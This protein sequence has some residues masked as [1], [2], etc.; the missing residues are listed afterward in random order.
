MKLSKKVGLIVGVVIIV[1]ALVGLYIVYS[2]QAR[3]RD[4]L[5]D[6][7]LRA[8]TLIPVLTANKQGQEDQLAS[9]TSSLDMSQA[10]FP[11]SVESIEYGEDLFEIAH[12]CNVDLIRLIPSMP[13]D[14]KVGAITYSV[15]QFVVMVR[16]NIENILEFI[17]TIRTG[18]YFQLPWSAEVKAININIAKLEASITLDIYGYKG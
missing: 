1:A 16:G 15:A 6:M 14:K 18:G 9:A 5:S 2:R 7:L 8:Q 17:Y 4:E 13:A 3:E 12:D 11:A 10:Q